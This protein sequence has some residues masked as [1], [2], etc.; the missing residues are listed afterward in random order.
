MDNRNGISGRKEKP[1]KK[2]GNAK[3]NKQDGKDRG[4]SYQQIMFSDLNWKLI[5]YSIFSLW[6]Q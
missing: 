4:D 3:Q 5:E 6:I 1:E 2:D